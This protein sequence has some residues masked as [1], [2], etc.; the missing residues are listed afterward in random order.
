M[1]AY[2][3]PGVVFTSTASTW[4]LQNLLRDVII[5]ALAGVSLKTYARRIPQG[6]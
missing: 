3:K 5:L 6:K 4:K 2:W 1:S